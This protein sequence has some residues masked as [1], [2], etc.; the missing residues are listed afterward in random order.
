MQTLTGKLPN[1]VASCTVV[2]GLPLLAF[3]ALFLQL[4]AARNA[5]HPLTGDAIGL[6]TMSVFSYWLALLSFGIGS[7]YFGYK[8]VRYHLSPKRWHLIALAWGAAEIAAPVLYFA[9]F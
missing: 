6:A 3:M 5:G 9:V 7:V 8:R 1:V 2:G 4:T